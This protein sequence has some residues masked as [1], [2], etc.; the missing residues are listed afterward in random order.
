MPEIDDLLRRYRP[1]EPPPELGARIFAARASRAWPW[2]A[3]AA[4]LLL[5]T[6][7]LQVATGRL[8]ASVPAFT[9]GSP[10]IED[11]AALLGGGEE[12][13]RLAEL[14]VLEQQARAALALPPPDAQIQEPI[15]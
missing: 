6:L 5:L 14:L 3:A 13:R 12:A 1:V 4:A 7:G 11:L 8:A 15:P 10:S 2:T 9:A